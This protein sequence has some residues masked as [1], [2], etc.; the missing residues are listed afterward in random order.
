MAKEEKLFSVECELKDKDFEE[1]FKIYLEAERRDRFIPLI[2]GAVLCVVCIVLTFALKNFMMIFYAVACLGIGLAYRF[3][4][5]NKKFLA[6]NRL[7]FGEKRELTFYPH[8]VTTFE[9]LDDED[10]DISEEELENAVVH[11][12]TNSMRAF[13]SKRGFVFA[14]GTITNNF[15]YVPKEG[16][17]DEIVAM[18]IDFA[19]NRCSG[20][21]VLL[22][23][24]SMLDTEDT[25]DLGSN[26]E[27]TSAEGV[28]EHYYGGN[29]LRI[30]DENGIRIQNDE[31]ASDEEAQ[32]EEDSEPVG[33][34]WETEESFDEL[35][36]ETEA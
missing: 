7:Q 1:V 31:D 26:G 5:A 23:T 18:L 2:V 11:F 12:S 20:G 27:D 24:Q 33:E 9:L 30:Y 16:T 14:D 17:D 8:E 13:E 3:V 34:N 25:V 29:K 21:Y 19:K 6:T 4:P 22:T 32:E 36:S 28:C 10:E 35:E 15:L